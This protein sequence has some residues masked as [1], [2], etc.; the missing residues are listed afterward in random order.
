MLHRLVHRSV[1]FGLSAVLTLSMLGG[2]DHLA[3]RD[4][5]PAGWAKA[6]AAATRA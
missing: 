6:V 1:S 5:P 4:E 3:Q 2:I